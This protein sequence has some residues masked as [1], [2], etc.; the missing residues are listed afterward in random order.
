[1]KKT[2]LLLNLLNNSQ[3]LT[4]RSLRVLPKDLIDAAVGQ[5]L[6]DAYADKSSP[7]SNTRLS[8]SFGSNYKPY[9]MFIAE[10]FK[11]FINSDVYAVNVKAKKDGNYYGNYRLKTLTLPVFNNLHK[12]FYEL[13]PVT[14]KYVKVVP[15]CIND[16]IS[17]IRLAHLIMSDGGYS[18]SRN[19]V[20]IFSYS[21]TYNDNIKLAESITNLG[22]KATVMKDR[23]N[24]DGKDQYIILIS[25]SQLDRLRKLVLPHIHTSIYYRVGA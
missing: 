10:L 13:D 21:F 14:N 25:S 12:L 19:L 5:L 3:L 2:L 20:R 7:T 6:G 15:K 22:V 16:L 9:A 18:K 11:D 8:W 17:S 1:M 4:V 24:K 23:V